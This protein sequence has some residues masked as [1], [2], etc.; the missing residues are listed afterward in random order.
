VT[1]VFAGFDED[2]TRRAR[3]YFTGYRPSSPSVALLRDG[4]L[5]FMLERSQIENQS[6]DQIAT[7]LVT[8]FDTY[9]GSLTQSGH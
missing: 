2:A 8:A 6:A 3:S 9:C 5:V 7:A 1:T 4:Q